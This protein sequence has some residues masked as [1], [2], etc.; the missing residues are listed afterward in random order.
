MHLRNYYK[1]ITGNRE[2]KTGNREAK[3]G[4]REVKT[5]K[6]TPDKLSSTTIY[7][8]DGTYIMIR[9]MV[10]VT[11]E[12]YVVCAHVQRGQDVRRWTD[13]LTH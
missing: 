3:T 11:M 12:A 6:P 2:T 8:S 1:A 5:S 7:F 4:N 10:R 9:R 13:S